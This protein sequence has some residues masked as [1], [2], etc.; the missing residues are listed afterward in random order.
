MSQDL[1]LDKTLEAPTGFVPPAV[2]P[3]PPMALELTAEQRQKVIRG[4]VE[5]ESVAKELAERS[6][7]LPEHQMYCLTSA[8]GLLR[9]LILENAN[10]GKTA[11]RESLRAAR[12]A[13]P[14]ERKEGNGL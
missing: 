7:I 14:T 2:H 4:F 1:H 3:L 9:L 13:L 11:A 10:A 5:I 12:G 8:V 6:G